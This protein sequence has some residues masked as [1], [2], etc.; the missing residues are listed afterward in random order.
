MHLAMRRKEFENQY[1][2]KFI[3]KDTCDMCKQEADKDSLRVRGSHDAVVVCFLCLKRE[4]LKAE[5]CRKD[6]REW[7]QI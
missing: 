2:G 3:D 1:R 7:P 5:S 4:Y 6:P